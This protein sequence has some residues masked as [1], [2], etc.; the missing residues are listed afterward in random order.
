MV[1]ADNDNEPP[2]DVDG[3]LDDAHDDAYRGDGWE[4]W[5]LIALVFI[6][7]FLFFSGVRGVILAIVWIVAVGLLLM[8]RRGIFVLVTI[9]LAL[10]LT[11]IGIIAL[12]QTV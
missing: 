6:V 11:I 7:A 8:L 12:F 10:A 1:H 4:M 9:V 5:A 3:Y 2:F